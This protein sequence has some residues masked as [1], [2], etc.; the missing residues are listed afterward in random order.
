MLVDYLVSSK[1]VLSVVLMDIS[2][3]EMMDALKVAWLVAAT[4]V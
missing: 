2:M 1:A 4:A 3:V